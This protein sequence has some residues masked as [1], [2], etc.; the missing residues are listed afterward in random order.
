MTE[1]DLGGL[2][3]LKGKRKGEQ[4]KPQTMG[5]RRRKHKTGV[6]G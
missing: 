1:S 5:E 3:G 4:I 2:G 6:A